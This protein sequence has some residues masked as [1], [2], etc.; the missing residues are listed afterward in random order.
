MGILR[1]IKM[2]ILEPN[3]G[4]SRILERR[5]GCPVQP[6]CP[7]QRRPGAVLSLGL[8]EWKGHMFQNYHALVQ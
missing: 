8:S 1:E 3:G 4:L 2:G 6:R 7:G 5:E